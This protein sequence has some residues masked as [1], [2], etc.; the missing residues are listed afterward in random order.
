MCNEKNSVG[1]FLDCVSS[2]EG[3]AATARIRICLPTSLKHYITSIV[4]SIALRSVIRLQ[5]NESS[6]AQIMI[7][8]EE[9]S[10]NANTEVD[11]DAA[12]DSD[13]TQDALGDL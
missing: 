13:T 2:F 4:L 12:Y 9:A 3:D 6:D 1:R 11:S 7:G 8:V 10:D 5:G